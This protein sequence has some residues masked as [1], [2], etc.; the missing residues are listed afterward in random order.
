[1]PSRADVERY[2]QA[3]RDIRTLVLADLTAIWSGLNLTDALAVRTALEEFL[4]LL[5]AQYGE[6]AA[7]VAADFYDDLR[8]K[9]GA[10]GRFRA[11]L[12]DPVDAEVVRAQAR[13]AIGPLFGETDGGA[14]LGRL[15]QVTDELTLRPGRLTIAQS[16]GHDPAKAR[17]A[18]VPVGKTCA[19][20]LM[21]AS[22][23]AVYGSAASA[24]QGR[25]FHAKDDCTPTPVWRNDPLPEG[26]DPDALLQQYMDARKAAD[27]GRPKAILAELR[28]ETGGH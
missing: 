10:P 20:C 21:L 23:G 1:M 9:A 12:A 14:A 19:F 28:Q 18:R 16:A 24:G 27:S 7:A 4:P 11:V 22:R 17:W 26:Y 15:Q 8:D 5:V 25:K 13:W 3:N 6:T 2:A